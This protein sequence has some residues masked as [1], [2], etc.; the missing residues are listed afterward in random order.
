MG[1]KGRVMTI[2]MCV[3]DENVVRGLTSS[4]RKTDTG[5]AG[6]VGWLIHSSVDLKALTEDFILCTA[7]S[8]DF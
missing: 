4:D 1:R 5:R 6:D 3:C 8:A 2:G 7:W